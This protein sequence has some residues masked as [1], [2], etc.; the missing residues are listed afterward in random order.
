MS[1]CA[2]ITLPINDQGKT[3]SVPTPTVAQTKTHT[4]KINPLFAAA[5]ASQQSTTANVQKDDLL[6]S[7]ASATTKERRVPNFEKLGVPTAPLLNERNVC[8]NA[9]LSTVY[10]AFANEKTLVLSPDH[11]WSMIAQGVSIHVNQNPEEFRDV[12][13]THQGKN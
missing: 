6:L 8:Q 12:F 4:T 5:F 3:R 9:Y 2:E 11:I 1:F 10:E 13:V 7:Y